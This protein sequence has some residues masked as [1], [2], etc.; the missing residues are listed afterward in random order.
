[1]ANSWVVIVRVHALVTKFKSPPLKI[2][3]N[4][5]NP[6]HSPSSYLSNIRI[7]FYLISYTYSYQLASILHIYGTKFCNC[8]IHFIRVTG[9]IWKS[10]NFKVC[11]H[12]IFIIYI[13]LR[14][15]TYSILKYSQNKIHTFFVPKVSVLFF[16][17]NVYWTPEIISYLLQ[18]TTRGKLHSVSNVFFH[19]S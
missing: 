17:L 19:W 10:R 13:L 16:Y 12:L 1:L 15:V 3:L 18:S 2:I 4:K 5:C 6:G 8:C 11:Q 7:Y 9:S 14:G